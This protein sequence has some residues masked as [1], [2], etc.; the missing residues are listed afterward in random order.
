MDVFSMTS[1]TEPWVLLLAAGFTLCF[2]QDCKHFLMVVK[3]FFCIIPK[4]ASDGSRKKTY[5]LLLL[6]QNHRFFHLTSREVSVQQN[7]GRKVDI[8]VRSNDSHLFYLYLSQISFHFFHP[9]PGGFCHEHTHWGSCYLHKLQNHMEN[10]WQKKGTFQG[11][12]GNRLSKCMKMYECLNY[13]LHKNTSISI[14]SC[15]HLSPLP[16]KPDVHCLVF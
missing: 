3:L 9:H 13:T 11:F 15:C 2:M 5:T 4:E 8:W 12:Q 6:T 7:S 16:P 10:G 1:S 14:K